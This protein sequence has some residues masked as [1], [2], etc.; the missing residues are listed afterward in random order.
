VGSGGWGL[1]GSRDPVELCRLIYETVA[2][3]MD[4]TVFF[5][6]LYDAALQTVEI[7][8]QVENGK[9]LSGGSFPLGTGL[10]SQVVLTGQPMLIR[11]WSEEGPRV[12][13]P[14]SGSS[15]L[16]YGATCSW[17]LPTNG[18]MNGGKVMNEPIVPV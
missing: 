1:V 3:Q 9:E 14:P 16:G 4:A 10:S 18:G 13:G 2:G 8:W 7:V 5:L 17:E 15:R 11:H 6:G 12:H